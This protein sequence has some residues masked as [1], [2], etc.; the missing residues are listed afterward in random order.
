[1]EWISFSTILLVGLS[2]ALCSIASW[3]SDYSEIS[4]KELCPI[5][6]FKDFAEEDVDHEE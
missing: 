6:R 1:M 2:V 4:F 5:H 3:A